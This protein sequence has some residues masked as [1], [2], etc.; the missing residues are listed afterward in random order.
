MILMPNQRASV[1]LSLQT[2]LA[3]TPNQQRN[4]GTPGY[5]SVG[6]SCESITR[7][8]DIRVLSNSI[9]SVIIDCGTFNQ[10]Y[11]ESMFNVVV[12][13]TCLCSFLL[14]AVPN[15]R[16]GQSLLHRNIWSKIANLAFCFKGLASHIVAGIILYKC[17]HFD[18]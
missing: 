7:L 17:M 9:T 8:L 18:L 1:V 4:S 13:L 10:T 15:L 12:R 16:L 11:L 3:E 14:Q 6:M 5:F 2:W